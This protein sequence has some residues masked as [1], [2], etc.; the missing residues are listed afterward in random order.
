MKMKVH[1]FRIKMD[2]SSRKKKKK[3]RKSTRKILA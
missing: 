3:K 1:K 2:K